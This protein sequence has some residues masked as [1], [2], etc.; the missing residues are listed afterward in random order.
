MPTV[1]PPKI[2]TKHAKGTLEKEIPFGSH[3]FHVLYLI[4]GCI[5]FNKKVAGFCQYFAHQTWGFAEA[6]D[7]NSPMAF[8]WRSRRWGWWDV[9]WGGD[10]SNIQYEVPGALSYTTTS[11]TL[12]T[13]IWYV[14][15][16][17]C[18]MKQCIVHLTTLHQVCIFGAHAPAHVWCIHGSE[19]I[20]F[21]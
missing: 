12:C 2:H 13:V 14:W 6:R 4:F 7:E 1:T 15:Y 11:T 5:V 17:W 9:M 16:V 20:V 19:Q 18:D 3:H 10:T 21:I 8:G